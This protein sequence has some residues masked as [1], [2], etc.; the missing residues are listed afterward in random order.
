MRNA[1]K[2]EGKDSFRKGMEVYAEAK[3][4][5]AVP[6]LEGAAG[7][8]PN[9]DAAVFYLGICY[10]MTNRPD[11]CIRELAKLT[12]AVSNPYREESHWYLAKAYFK[13]GDLA[14]ARRELESVVAMN[15]VYVN[16]ARKSLQLMEG[17]GENLRK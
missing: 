6:L 11:E 14:P 5:E 1:K 13:K 3:Y 7:K 15:G 4:K 17:L 2:V 16:E 12:T 9:H 10:L 8:E